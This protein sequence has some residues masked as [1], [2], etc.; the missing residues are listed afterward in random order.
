M[1][2]ASYRFFP[3]GRARPRPQTIYPDQSHLLRLT[4]IKLKEP[5]KADITLYYC[6]FDGMLLWPTA[7]RQH[8]SLCCC[9]KLFP[10]VQTAQ[11]VIR[12][13][14]RKPLLIR[15]SIPSLLSSSWHTSYSYHPLPILTQSVS[16]R[17]LPLAPPRPLPEQRQQKRN[18][19]RPLHLGF[20]K[21]KTSG[22]QHHP[23]NTCK[24]KKNKTT[25][26]SPVHPTPKRYVCPCLLGKESR[27]SRNPM[28]PLQPPSSTPSKLQSFQTQK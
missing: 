1:G 3:I 18:H 23:G 26:A 19:S 12:K 28:N 11:H 4:N 14:I 9:V 10:I 20:N 21:Q 2:P 24:V 17:N 27:K 6:D 15:T 13:R 5:V 7:G 25:I 8:Q 22:R 16:A